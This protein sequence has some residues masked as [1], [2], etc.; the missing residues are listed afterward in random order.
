MPILDFKPV[1]KDSLS[2][3]LL[4]ISVG[5]ALTS[6]DMTQMQRS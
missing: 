6:Y 3:I 1:D 4:L 5:K 2:S